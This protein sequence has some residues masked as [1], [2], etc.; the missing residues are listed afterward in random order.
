MARNP[1]Q[2]GFGEEY[3]TIDE[4][5]HQ[6]VYARPIRLSQDCLTCHGDLPEISRSHP[7]RK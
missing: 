3:F 1:C 5:R 6:M 2:C 4:Q 7:A